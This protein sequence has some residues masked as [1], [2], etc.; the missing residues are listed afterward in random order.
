MTFSN[1]LG[2]RAMPENRTPKGEQKVAR[3]LRSEACPTTETKHK[4]LQ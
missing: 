3:R 2:D 4:G 1:Q